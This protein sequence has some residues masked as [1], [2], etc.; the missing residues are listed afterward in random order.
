MAVQQVA[1]SR[2]TAIARDLLLQ[3]R[4]YKKQA[5]RSV[6]ATGSLEENG[7]SKRDKEV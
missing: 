2:E 4:E 6:R 1:R 7:V 3:K 5:G